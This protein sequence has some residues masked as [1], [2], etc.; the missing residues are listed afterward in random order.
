MQLI[1]VCFNNGK[2][3]SLNT[4]SSLCKILLSVIIIKGIQTA[5][6]KYAETNALIIKLPFVFTEVY[7]D[8]MNPQI[9]K[10]NIDYCKSLNYE[11]KD[12][13]SLSCA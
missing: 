8:S 3:F 10:F 1:T 13:I 2:P 6:A 5:A 11:S 7:D 12:H 9:C 4:P